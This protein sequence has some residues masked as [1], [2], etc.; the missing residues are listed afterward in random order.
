MRVTGPLCAPGSPELLRREHRV[1]PMPRSTACFTES[2]PDPNSAILDRPTRITQLETSTHNW[3]SALPS[4]VLRPRF[5]GLGGGWC[6]WLRVRRAGRGL[7]V[8]A[9]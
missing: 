9:G 5:T 8:V 6:S 1:D 7:G 4:R 3:R 2:G